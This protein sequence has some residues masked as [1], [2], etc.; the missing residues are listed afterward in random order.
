M[1]C[2]TLELRR[3]DRTSRR[4]S[5]VKTKNLTKLEEKVIL[6]RILELIERGFSSRLDDVRDIA[7]CLRETRDA[8]S[9]GSR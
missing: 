2:T 3:N 7:D 9:V 5:L 6:N 4:D 8:L 1:S